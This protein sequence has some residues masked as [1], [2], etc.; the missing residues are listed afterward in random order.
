MRY[1][2]K[3][4]VM[5]KSLQFA[6]KDAAENRQSSVICDGVILVMSARACVKAMRVCRAPSGI[7]LTDA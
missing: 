1:C 3:I 5:L 4:D 2:S 6:V 7:T